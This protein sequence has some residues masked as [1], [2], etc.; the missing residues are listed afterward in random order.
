PPP[1]PP[2]PPPVIVEPPVVPEVPV[3]EPQLTSS[4]YVELPDE[5]TTAAA[6][7]VEEADTETSFGMDFP[8]MFNPPAVSEQGLVT[9]AVTSGGDSATNAWKGDEDEEEQDE[10]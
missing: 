3:I 6:A 5:V 8:K 2:P 4:T 10:D 9:D 7:L 1:P